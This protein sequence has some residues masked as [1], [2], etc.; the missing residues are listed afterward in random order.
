[1][2]RAARIYLDWNATAPLREAAACVLVQAMASCGN[3]SS[4]HAEGRAARAALESARAEVARLV[5]AR[6]DAVIFTSGGTEANALALSPGFGPV[7]AP[8]AEVLLVGAGEH[9]CVLDGH[10]FAPDAVERIPLSADGVA[11]L[12]WLEARIAEIAPRRALVSLQLANSETG[13]IQPVAEAARIAHAHGA[14]I[15]TDAVQAPGRIPV[16]IRALGVDALTL[17]AHKIGG[18]QG[19]GALVLASGAIAVDPL[20]R[21]GGQERGRRAGTENVPALVAFGAAARAAR[22]GLPTE[23]A[24]LAALG[25][26]FEAAIRRTAPG[27]VIF[28]ERAPRLPNTILF[29]VPGLR[30][31]TALI[32]FDLG[33][34][35]LSSGSACSSGKV[36][37][38]HVLDAMG[39]EPALA[40]GA[41]RVSWG[42]ATDDEAVIRF[43]SVLEDVEERRARRSQAA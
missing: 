15:H 42:W 6:A 29:A 19:A 40:E 27:A 12:A 39:V 26:A 24:R 2:D 14:S 21:G 5:D 41:L 16:S 9:P 35:A 23:S 3:A 22:E 17:S 38:S 1:M 37:R 18:P 36:R 43:A 28:G 4:V 31:E 10:R 32:A 7:G 34:V 13:V 25:P 8:R 11:D 20:L 30:A 33:G